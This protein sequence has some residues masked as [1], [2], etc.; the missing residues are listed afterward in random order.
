MESEFHFSLVCSAYQKLRPFYFPRSYIPC[1][2]FENLMKTMNV[3]IVYTCSIA[4]FIVLANKQGLEF[5]G[6]R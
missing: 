6:S 5:V 2:N 1:P 3:K 4:K